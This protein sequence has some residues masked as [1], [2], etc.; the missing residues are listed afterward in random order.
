MTGQTSRGKRQPDRQRTPGS[1]PPCTQGARCNGQGVLESGVHAIF[2]QGRI[3]VSRPWTPGKPSLYGVHELPPA[4]LIAPR[5]SC[6]PQLLGAL[7]QGNRRNWS[8][9]SDPMMQLHRPRPRPSE[10]APVGAPGGASGNPDSP[11]GNVGL[12]SG[13]TKHAMGALRR[14]SRHG[15]ASRSAQLEEG[16]PSAHEGVR[17]EHEGVLHSADGKITRM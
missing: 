14:V 12:A 2:N 16:S 13:L 11:A 1:G 4:P 17:Q 7:I 5:R 9:T 6:R 8:Q 3:T 15:E 10:T